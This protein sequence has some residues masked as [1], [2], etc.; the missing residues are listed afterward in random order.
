[1]QL[2]RGESGV[3]YAVP[4]NNAVV[5]FLESVEKANVV[6]EKGIV[7]NDTLVPVLPLIKG[8]DANQ[9]VG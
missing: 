5:I 2:G 8:R 7:G 3:N 4:M 1:M 6:V 9:E